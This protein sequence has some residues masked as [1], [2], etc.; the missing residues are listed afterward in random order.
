MKIRIVED[1]LP[2][3]SGSGYAV[4]G[5][6]S[7]KLYAFFPDWEDDEFCEYVD[8]KLAAER[9]A[10][11]AQDDADESGGRCNVRIVRVRLED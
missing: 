5:V 2:K 11:D 6:H 7:N 10:E 4:V 3:I 1:G 8:T 9:F